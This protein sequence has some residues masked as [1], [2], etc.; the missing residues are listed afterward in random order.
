MFKQVLYLVLILF[1]SNWFV[2][3]IF[4]SYFSIG[5]CLP[6]INYISQWKIRLL[7]INGYL[8]IAFEE[9]SVDLDNLTISCIILEC[10][11]LRVTPLYLRKI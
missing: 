8:H 5:L 1:L 3:G 2:W 9:K 10:S 4:V 11:I 6:F 7:I